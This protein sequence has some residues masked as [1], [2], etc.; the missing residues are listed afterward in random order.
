L[1]QDDRMCAMVS[2]YRPSL[3]S[4]G[5]TPARPAGW[6]EVKVRYR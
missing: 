4:G 2:A 5:P 3:L 1:G 6:G